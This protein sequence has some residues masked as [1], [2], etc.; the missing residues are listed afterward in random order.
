MDETKFIEENKQFLN[1]LGIDCQKGI[2]IFGYGSLVWRVNFKYDEK[3]VGYI[4]GYVRRFW[5]TSTD[6]RG[7]E[8]LVTQ[9][10]VIVNADIICRYRYFL[11]EKSAYIPNYQFQKEKPNWYL[12]VQ[13]Q[14]W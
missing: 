11:S 4:K 13:S 2:W 9:D 7:S 6:H 12:F 3:R 5:Q 10:I 8:R 1:S 14:Q